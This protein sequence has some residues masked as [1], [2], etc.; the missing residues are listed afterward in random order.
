MGYGGGVGSALIS[1]G[2]GATVERSMWITGSNYHG[3]LGLNEY[4]QYPWQFSNKSSPMQIGTN[5][6]WAF[7][8]TGQNLHGGI[9]N[10]NE[11]FSWGNN[12]AG[13]TGTNKSYPTTPVV[14]STVKIPGTWQYVYSGEKQGCAITTGGELFTWGEDKNGG[15]GINKSPWT[16]TDPTDYEQYQRPNNYSSPVSLGGT[17]W[18]MAQVR[19]NGGGGVK[20]DGTAWFWGQMGNASGKN[21]SGITRSSPTQ[22]GGNSDYWQWVNFRAGSWGDG[23]KQAPWQSYGTYYVW[24]YSG[25]G[26]LGMNAGGYDGDYSSPQQ[27]P[28]KSTLPEYDLSA[29]VGGITLAKKPSSIQFSTVHTGDGWVINASST[30]GGTLWTCGSG[31]NG[32]LGLNESWTPTQPFSQYPRYSSFT[33]VGAATDWSLIDGSIGWRG[34]KSGTDVSAFVWGGHS[35]GSLGINCGYNP[36]QPWSHC[37]GRSSPTSIGSAPGV[38]RDAA[39]SAFR[40]YEA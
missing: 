5:T 33:Q 37:G 16:Y 32:T 22:M 39:T 15:L 40:L 31:G 11:L 20:T 35:Y 25:S 34:D 29:G 18:K 8:S 4:A 19:E 17:N 2:A 7:I 23:I 30:T 24:G 3:S 9:T 21:V 10:T 26:S 27:V 13:K 14:K 36:T 1:G 6:N 28:G 38:I 12:N